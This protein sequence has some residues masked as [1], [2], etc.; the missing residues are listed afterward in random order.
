MI[1]MFV[2]WGIV[3]WAFAPAVN[4]ALAKAA[5]NH[6]DVALALNMTAMN[7]G[8]AAGSAIG[9]AI[10][11]TSGVANVVSAGAV[12]LALAFAIAFPLPRERRQ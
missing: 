1:V 4:H 5:G 2:V 11:A 6:R 8:I 7:L 10:V 12:L 3:S 9:G